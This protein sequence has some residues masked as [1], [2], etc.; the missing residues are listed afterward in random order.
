MTMN[1]F[2]PRYVSFDIESARILPPGASELLA[3]RPLGI[4]CASACPSDTG[5][6]IVWHGRTE[7]GSSSSTPSPKM[8]R[9]ENAKMVRD[10]ERFVADGYTLV[11]WNGLGFDFDILAEESGLHAECAELATN[12]IDMLFH[13]VC[14]LGH[15]VSLQKASEGMGIDGKLEAMHGAEAPQ[16]WAEGRFEEVLAYVKQDAVVTVRL[17]EIAEERA[18]LAWISRTGNRRRMPL[19]RGWLKV[20]DA[21]RLPLPDTSWMHAAPSRDRYTGWLD[22]VRVSLSAT[23]G[24]SHA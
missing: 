8:T 7:D 2:G 9:E 22:Q 12:H 4:S 14:V 17:A 19:D 15:P 18:E 10:L 3:Y 11:T 5:T 24:A 21:A 1:L 16:A 6:A 13:A 23:T 20:S